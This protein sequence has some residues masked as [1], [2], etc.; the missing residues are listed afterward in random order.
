MAFHG[1]KS[2]K[3]E[4][5]CA[6]DFEGD[7]KLGKVPL[8]SSDLGRA[9]LNLFSNGFEALA[10]KAA[11][12]NGEYQPRMAVVV[13][14]TGQ[15]ATI[16]IRDNGSGISP[17]HLPKIFDPFFTTKPPNE[18]TG[19]GLSLAHETIVQAHGG[20]VKVDS[21]LGDYTEFTISLPL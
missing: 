15:E 12:A 19:L 10:G 9:L 5:D 8:V 11:K 2:R 20:K 14:K 6:V 3:P 7:E 18:G 21:K 13:K 4:Y 1:I 16:T 17:E